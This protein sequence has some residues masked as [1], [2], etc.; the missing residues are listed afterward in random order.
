VNGNVFRKGFVDSVTVG[1]LGHEFQHLINAS[2]RIYVND[3]DNWEDTWLNEGLSHVAEELLFDRA[4]GLTTR[5]RLD[6][7]TMRPAKIASAFNYYMA[8][9]N[10]QRLAS[11]FVA[12]ETI[13]PYSDNDDLETR[14]AT[15]A[16]LRYAADRVNGNDAA[17]WQKLVKDTKLNGMPNLRAALGV[18]AA[19]LTDWFRD[20]TI[21]NFADGFAGGTLDARYTYRS[22]NLR[23]VMGALRT[24]R[25]LLVYP[26]YP[27]QTRTLENG[28]AETPTIRGGAAA[29]FRFAVGAGKQGRIVTVGDGAKLPSG[30]AV[31]VMRTK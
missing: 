18:D 7:L 27:L 12:G 11:Y 20:W 10:I 22:W 15:W 5:T 31:S 3:T 30:I 8:S 28:Q 24:P 1:T 2:R 19:T 21:A 9:G 6:S 16:F 17:L 29:Y 25:N 14:G 23:S 26:F 4:A 13:S